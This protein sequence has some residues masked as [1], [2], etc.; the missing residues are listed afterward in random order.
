MIK[1]ED[2]QNEEIKCIEK[3]LVCSITEELEMKSSPIDLLNKSE[4]KDAGKPSNL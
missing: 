2:D 3:E 4:A 1:K